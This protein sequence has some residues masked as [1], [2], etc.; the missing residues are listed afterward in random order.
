M[1]PWMPFFFIIVLALVILTLDECAERHG[2]HLSE[3]GWRQNP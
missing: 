2:Y 3:V 1:K